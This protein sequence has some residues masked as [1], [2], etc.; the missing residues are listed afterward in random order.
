MGSNVYDEEEVVLGSSDDRRSSVVSEQLDQC[1]TKHTVRGRRRSSVTVT[2]SGYFRP[3]PEGVPVDNPLV[4]LLN[5]VSSPD[6][7]VEDLEGHTNSQPVLCV[8][9]FY[10]HAFFLME[11][12]GLETTPLHCFLVEIEA[13]YRP[14]PYHSTL[15]AADVVVNAVRLLNQTSVSIKFSPLELLAMIIACAGSLW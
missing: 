15:H 9:V 4:A 6:F 10:C 13:A 3:T 8:V 7:D 14:V 1:A 11:S 5:Q 12:L 2:N